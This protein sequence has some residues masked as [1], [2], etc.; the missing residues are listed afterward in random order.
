MCHIMFT[1]VFN[2]LG[3]RLCVCL[4]S[5][6]GDIICMFDKVVKVGVQKKKKN[7]I[8]MFNKA[9]KTWEI[10]KNEK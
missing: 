8:K 5:V 1:Y 6:V 4:F 10:P 2:I 9:M 7:E 3:N